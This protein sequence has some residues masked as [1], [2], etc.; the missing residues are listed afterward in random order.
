[1]FYLD[2]GCS[3]NTQ[4]WL[5]SDPW[6]GYRPENFEEKKGTAIE[7]ENLFF[8]GI[9]LRFK[10]K[11]R[12]AKDFFISYITNHPEEQAAYVELF[13][14]YNNETGND[15]IRFFKS[16]PVSA[17]KEHKLLL[18]NL[19]LNGGM[20]Q[21]A[22]NNNNEIIQGN[23]NTSLETAA[24][25]INIYI[26]L[27]NDNDFNAACEIFKDV[28]LYPGLSTPLELQ[29]VQNSIESYAS[30]NG[31]IVPE[32]FLSKSN[33]I[34]L[35]LPNDYFLFVNYPNPFNPSTLINYSIK[36]AGLV[37][38]EVFDILGSEVATLVNE[39][40][41]AGNFSVE[42]NAANLPSGVYIYTLQ[43]NG[44]TSS[45]KMLLMK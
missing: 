34:N 27:Y 24:K 42:F 9:K 8:E 36:E 40:K 18:S 19:Y 39:T 10:K 14:C 30:Q 31:L 37:K 15:L 28:M 38:I 43:V 22:K 13:N 17:S 5:A 20:I 35:T 23:P 1:M 21:E 41:E 11:F 6:I 29:L 26:A 44:F 33:N 7:Q 4:Y 25:I 16:L 3:I 2:A 45:K 32:I 12:E